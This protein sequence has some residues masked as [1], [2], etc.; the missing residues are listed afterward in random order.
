M[1][2]MATSTRVGVF[3]A[4]LMVVTVLPAIAGAEADQYYT[5]SEVGTAVIDPNCV[6]FFAGC[7]ITTSASGRAAYIGHT[8]S[9]SKGRIRL[10]AEPCLL[11]D[12]V[13]VGLVF[14]SFGTFTMVG[15]DGSTISGTYENTGCAGDET[16]GSAINGSQTIKRGTGQF[17]GATGQTVT[18]GEGHGSTFTLRWIGTISY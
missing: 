13:T 5:G 7:S 15:A 18:S 2:R 1:V 3:L 12:R 6:D 8:T 9:T 4:V 14:R 10:F 16:I 11:L 17:A